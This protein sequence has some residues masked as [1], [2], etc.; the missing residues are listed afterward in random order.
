MTVENIV[1][2][3]GASGR[4]GRACVAR[5]LD[6]GA[7][8]RA[9][10]RREAAA[11]ELRAQGVMEVVV[12]DMFAP[13]AM[14]RA[15]EGVH[16]VLHIC[17]PMHPQEDELAIE[18]IARAKEAV[19]RRFVLWSVLHPHI[20]VPHHRRKFRAESALI[21]SGLAFT[22]L[23]PCRYMQH[24]ETIWP[25]IRATGV[26]SFPFSTKSRFSLAHID[27][28]ASAAANILMSNG[29]ENA[30]YELAGP[31]ALSQDDCASIIAEVTGRNVRAERA[32]LEIFLNKA[33]AAEM[34]E[35][36]IETLRVMNAHY[37]LHGLNGNGNVLGWL[38]GRPARTFRDYV[39][40][41]EAR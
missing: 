37:D 23:Q 20:D 6:K 40:E 38:L 21:D 39:S 3:T 11:V 7:S 16:A 30:V 15:L 5:L 27:D 28:L 17:P 24:L 1:L 12:G 25:Q 8:L 18:M 14:T 32:S 4:T 35:W 33:R 34:P 10:V 31:D 41:F 2:V 36:R 29:H 19:V 13:D 9:F 26:H 22:I